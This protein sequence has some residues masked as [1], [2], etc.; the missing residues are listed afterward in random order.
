MNAHPDLPPRDFLR[1][2]ITL[3]AVVALLMFGWMGLNAY[4]NVQIAEGQRPIAERMQRVG[5]ELRDLQEVMTTSSRI[6]ATNGDLSP[7]KRYLKAELTFDRL[8][9]EADRLQS[10]APAGTA[11]DKLLA[12]NRALVVAQHAAFDLIRQGQ[13]KQAWQLLSSEA[14]QVQHERYAQGLIEFAAIQAHA[15]DIVD[16]ALIRSRHADALKVFIAIPLLVLLLT[17]G[18]IW[19]FRAIRRW[20]TLLLQN[21]LKLSRKAEEL[22]EFN[23]QLDQKV[24]ERTQELTDSAI[25]SLNMM[26]D[27]VRQREQTEQA[28]EKL[29]YLAYYDELTG[30]ANQTLFLQRVQA[31]LLSARGGEMLVVFVL[32]ILRFKSINDAFGRQGGD[33]LL[34]QIAERLVSVGGGGA[35]RFARIGPDRFAVVATDL[36][37]A[38]RTGR[39]ASERLDAIFH[40]PFRISDRNV[41]ISAK[42]GIA[43]FPV[44]GADADALLRNAEAALKK[45]KAT[46]ELFLFFTQAMTDRVAERLSLEH[47]LRQATDNEEFV[48]HYQPKVSVATG[49]LT[50]AEALIRWNDPAT[51]LMQPATFIPILEETQLI[52]Q[53]GRWAIRKAVGDYLR[54]RDLGL[55]A[56]P[57]AVNVSPLQ[58][59]NRAFVDELRQVVAL[60]ERAAEGLEL[61]ITES[62]IMD[63][64]EH[65]IVTLHEIRA[66]GVR[67]AIDDFGTG[68]SSLAYLSKLPIDTLKIDRTFVTEMM[69]GTQGV[70]L[71]NAIINLAH[72]LQLSVVAEGVET[73]EQTRMLQSMRCD[74]MQGY[75][76]SEP[77]PQDLFQSKYLT[78]T[79]QA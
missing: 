43:L 19:V 31:K 7:E 2:R 9:T 69:T 20:Q 28:Q 58:L 44:D 51:G 13:S 63:D 11:T 56:V 33:D 18:L 27:A 60:D 15:D 37:S 34:K 54:W 59:R 17:L 76:L 55:A 41:S 40:P 42:L 48:L 39:Y 78:M 10:T 35:D 36:E 22:V 64:I 46:G 12:A 1:T 45:A 23:V 66:M 32:D 68:F 73:N 57:I 25:A 4:R 6:A 70:A 71:V 65:A 74:E 21:N 26:E 79:A 47:R 30:L 62:M 72:S 38:Q 67:I 8:I 49:K 24:R 77:I 14:Q 3:L 61:E 53:V 16:D 52:Q 5:S 29:N 50:G 75:L